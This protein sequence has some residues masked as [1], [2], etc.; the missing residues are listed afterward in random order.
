MRPNTD[1]NERLNRRAAFVLALSL[2]AA[3]AVALY[4]Q[5][6][7]SPT[8]AKTPSDIAAS[9]AAPKKAIAVP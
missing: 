3:L 5:T 1:K 4:V 9:A 8:P 7:Q 6:S 2:H